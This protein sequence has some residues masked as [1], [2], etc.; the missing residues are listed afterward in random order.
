VLPSQHFG[1]VSVL[2]FGTQ[3][4]VVERH[5]ACNECRAQCKPDH[6]RRL[7]HAADESNSSDSS[8]DDSSNEDG[9]DL[10][11]EGD[12]GDAKGDS[13]ETAAG[14]DVCVDGRFC[15]SDECKLRHRCFKCKR[16]LPVESFGHAAR[17]YRFMQAGERFINCGNCRDDLALKARD[18]NKR[19]RSSSSRK[20]RRAGAG[21]AAKAAGATG[22]N[23]L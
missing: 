20:G 14:A 17:D 21:K 3:R 12:D 23:R 18:L 11:D 5:S 22:N 15:K 10:E 16:I 19:K 6:Q 2:Q 4:A 8:S 9:D 13:K 1:L 7:Q